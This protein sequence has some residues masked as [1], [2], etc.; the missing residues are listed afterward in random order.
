LHIDLFGPTFVK[1]LSKKSYY[2]VVTN[3]YSRSDNGTEFENN[4]FNQFCGM[5]GIKG[6]FSEPRTP[7]QN[8][9]AE[10]KNRTLIKA[11]RTML[12][13]YCSK[14]LHVNFLENKPN[15][16]G[17]GPIWLFDIDSLT[18]TMNY[19]PVSAGNQ[20]YVLFL[21][22]SSHFINPYN[23]DG[24]AAFEGKEY[25]F[26][27]KKPKS[28]V[29][30]SS[31]SSAQSMKQDDKTKKEAKGKSPVESFTRNRDLSAKFEDCFDNSSNEVNA[32]GTIVSTVRQ[33]SSNSTNPFSVVGPSNTTTR[34]TYGKSSFIDASQPS[35]DPD[36]LE[37]D[38]I[39][40]FDDENDVGA[41][42]DFNNLETSITEELL[43]FKMQK[44]WVLVDLP[45]GKR[46]I[47]TKWVYRNKKDER[48]IVVKNKPL[49][50]E[51][52]DHHDKVYKVVKA[53]YGL[54][55]ALR[56]CQDKYVAEILRKFR[57]IEGKSAS[58]PIDIEKPLLKDHDGD[59]VDVHTYRSM[60]GSLLY[61][62][63]SRPDIMFACKKQTVVATSSTE[64]KYVAAASCCAQVNDVTRLQALVNKKKVVVTKA[65]IRELSN[66]V[67]CHLFIHRVETPLFEGM[68]V[69]QEIEEEGDADEHVEDVTVGDDAQGDDTTAHG[70][71][72]AITQEPSIP[73]PTP[74]IPPSQPP[75]DIP[76]TSQYDKVAQA[77]EI[78]K[79]KRRV[80]RLEKGNKAR[81]LK[82]RRLKKVGTSQRVDTSNETVMDDES[83]QGRMIDE[84]DKDDVIILIDEKEEDTKVEETMLDESAQ[85]Q[86]RQAESQ[87]KIYK[88]DMNHA[89]KVLSMQEDEPV[90][91]QE[92]VDVVTTAML[93]IEVVTAASEI[94]TTV[95]AIISA[96]EPQVPAATITTAPTKVVAAPSR[97][98]KGV[99][100]RD[101]EEESTTSSIISTETKS[102]DKG[103]RI[104]VEEPKSLKKKQ[105]IE[106][107]EQYGRK[108][109]AE[110]NKDIDWDI[111][112]DHVK[113]KCKEDP[114]NIASFKLDYFK[115]MSYDDI[116]PI[117]EAKFNTNIKFL[118]KTKEQIEE[119]ENKVL[120]ST[121]ET[122]AQKK[123]KRRKLNR[124]VKDLK[125]HLEIMPNEDDDVYTEA[126]PLSRKVPIM[127]YKIIEL[128]NKPYYKI[129]RGD[130]T[131]QLYISF[132]TLLKNFNREDLEALCSLVKERLKS[133]RI[134]GLYMVKKRSRSGSYWNYVPQFPLNY[135]LEPGYIENY[136]SYPYDSSSLPQQYPCCEDC[137]VLPEADHCQTPQY[138]VNHPIFNAHKD[139]LSSQTTLMEQM[140]QLTSM[141]EMACQ[142]VQKKKEEKR[143][144]EEQAANAKIGRS[145][146]VVMMTTITILQSHQINPLTLSN[147]VPNPSESDGENGCDVP[148]CFTTFSN[149][150]FD[151]DYDFYSVDDQ[152]LSDEDFPK[153]IYSNPL[154][155]EEI[156][157]MKIDPHHFNAGSDLIESLLNHDSFIISSSSKIDSLF[158]EFAEIVY[159]NSSPHPPEELVSEIS[160]SEI[161]SFSPSPIPVEDSDSFMKEIDLSFTPDDPMPPSIGEDN[162]DSERDIP[163]LEELLDN[164]SLSLPKNESFYFDIP[165]FSRPPAKPPDGNTGILNIKMMGDIS[166]QKYSW[167]FEDSYRRILSFKS[168]FSQLQLGIILVR[169]VDSF[170]KFYMYPRFLQLMIRAQVGDLSSHTINYSSPA[171]TQKVFANMRRV[172][173]G[174]SRVETPLFEGMI[175]AQQADDVAD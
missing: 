137:E 146:L 21:V 95:S 159:E 92:V 119:E 133:R 168:S 43:Q 158:D 141:C 31:S 13:P 1:S 6:E 173:N 36:M 162:Y 82:L 152:S 104:M 29:I 89:S 153:E 106:M 114:A 131:H 174:F 18:R 30:L 41:E 27:A 80:R 120:Q 110:I 81:V 44:V 94:V 34:P 149:I 171:L 48:G 117:F 39:T 125:R 19:Q 17:S 109:H 2:L 112:I 12:N 8:G 166:E 25:D 71:V 122:P 35:D 100:I 52:L 28:K 10:R 128:N 88:I 108:L 73:S 169:N 79:L 148:A 165:S 64:A 143:I 90:E 75:Q 9:I 65:A 76:S 130:G 126:T 144:E 4:D 101:P 24:D 11:A 129:I 53:L 91:V 97:R 72:L 127:D 85:V 136:N 99:V 38:D 118:L 57:L 40:Y 172:G 96:A 164:Y 83:N 157:S 121:N 98:R 135:E 103:K 56:A 32:V 175:A 70:E 147:L 167:K 87:A 77:L 140:T 49:E 22:W 7:Q 68:L 132:L 161:E 138:T 156:N 134:K 46:A 124:E 3:D 78:T 20:Q 84:M 150:L 63:S 62:T 5:K 16:A 23:Y 60:I 107:D 154:F 66:G 170:T 45:H 123:A 105:Q 67:Y 151:A 115:G 69:R 116:R 58:T 26:D 37:L 42:A 145:P 113:L 50:F 163:I 160:N 14:T 33:N 74:T 139:L 51:D 142:I 93:I 47:G 15:I 55:K 111:A 86:E 61:L 155:N 59:D 54:H 102:K